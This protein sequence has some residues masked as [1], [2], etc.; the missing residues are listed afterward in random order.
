[1]L[2]P[3]VKRNFRDAKK[4]FCFYG[5]RVRFSFQMKCYNKF[6]HYNHCDFLKMKISPM[7]LG[8]RPPYPL[9]CQVL[10]L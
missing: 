5:V 8:L 6:Y 3:F 4:N 1:M 9:I 7:F 10:E 2:E